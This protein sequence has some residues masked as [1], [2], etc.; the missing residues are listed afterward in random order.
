MPSGLTGPV[1][2]V[3]IVTEWTLNALIDDIEQ[4]QEIFEAP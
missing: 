3:D 2:M 1:I 4:L